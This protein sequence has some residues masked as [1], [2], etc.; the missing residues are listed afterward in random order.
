MQAFIHLDAVALPVA[1]SN[2]NTDQI[3]PARFLRKQRAD[4]FGQYLFH[5]L[6]FGEDGREL[7]EFPMNQDVYRAPGVI[8]ARKN[9]GCGS[10]REM[11][12][13]AISDFGV[14]AIVAPS[15]ADIFFNNCVRNGILCV[16]LPEQDVED[17]LALLEAQPGTRLQLDLEGQK[18]VV[19]N[20]GQYSF[21][22]DPFNKKCLLQGL[23]S[24]DYT[25]RF[26]D[27]IAEY[28]AR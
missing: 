6:R 21:P 16:V 4:G 13:W 14:R 20:G 3:I 17:I 10:S 26:A 7:A 2:V 18:L 25:L 9:F 24:I 11:A 15:F 5:D 23:D 28:E 12:V 22:V 1:A 19:E 27:R 8:V